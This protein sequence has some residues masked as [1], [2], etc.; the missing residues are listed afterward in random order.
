MRFAARQWIAPSGRAS[1]RRQRRAWPSVAPRLAICCAAIASLA[2]AFAEVRADDEPYTATVRADSV[3]VR[4]GPGTTYYATDTLRQGDHVEVYGVDADGWCRVRPPPGSFSWI[5]ADALDVKSGG[6]ARVTRDRAEAAVGSRSGERRDTVQVLLDRDEVVELLPGQ[7]AGEGTAPA[8]YKIAPPAGEFRWIHEHYLRPESA[9][10]QERRATRRPRGRSAEDDDRADLV[11]YESE[12]DQP[13]RLRD[14]T[15]MPV[16]SGGAA[17]DD[18]AVDAKLHKLELEVA[19]IAAGKARAT[20]LA[21]LE[22]DA[23][24]VARQ[25]QSESDRNRA[26]LLLYRVGRMT[27]RGLPAARATPGLVQE[28]PLSGLLALA[29]YL[30]PG[31]ASA[32]VLPTYPVA[33]APGAAGILPTYPTSPPPGAV[34]GPIIA[35]YFPPPPTR[36]FVSLDALGWWAK[37]DHLPPLVTTSPIG[38]PQG[39][40]GVLGLPTTSILFGN[41]NVLGDIRPGGRVQGG[42]WLDPYQVFAIEG[43]YFR[44]ATEQTTFSATSTFSTG[45]T[46]DPILAR[47]FFNASPAVNAQSSIVVAFPNFILIPLLPPTTINL[48]GTV[49]VRESSNIQSAGGGGRLALV[50]Y[51]RP[52]RF[53]A[54]GAYRFF[55]LDETLSILNSSNPGIGPF[56]PGNVQSFDNFA[57]TN[58]FNGGEIG[59]ATEYWLT[60]WSLVAETRLA[61]GNMHETLSID[62]RTSAISGGFDASYLGGLLTQ[63]TNI[64]TYTRDRFVLIP[65]VDVKLGFQLLPPL[66]LTVGYNFTYVTRVLR[67]GDQVDTTVNTTQV[68]GGTLVGPARPQTPFRDTGLWLQGVTAGLDLRF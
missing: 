27:G 14:L 4:S 48:D 22:A 35:P 57:T 41:Q 39:Q 23:R 25:A 59:L 17:N 45:S 36:H 2:I 65:Q 34:P 6:T 8:W 56:P 31:E 63:P 29:Q 30:A 40:A 64:G 26:E 15:L 10:H 13:G 5:A 19:E 52:W 67:P 61:M 12:L 44:L 53:F 37:A 3:H 32:P 28:S 43:N 50:P 68:A 62:G 46:T 47:P 51:T 9:S 49:Q 33:P 21:A 58:V 38:T 54:L 24:D 60:R 18:R 66:R 7:S 20:N 55:E 42:V 11:G 16:L 1:A